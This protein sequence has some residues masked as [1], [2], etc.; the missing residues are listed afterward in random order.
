M[1]EFELPRRDALKAGAGLVS[2]AAAGLPVAALAA[3][4]WKPQVF[5]AHQ[6]ATVDQL[7][8]LIIPATDTPGA[9]AAGVVRYVDL[10]LNDGPD[11]E[12]ARFLEGLSWLDG[13]SLNKHQKPFV[14]LRE[15]EQTGVL[16]T[17]DQQLEVGVE[18][19]HRFFRMAKSLT[20]RI[21]YNTKIGYDELNK[22]GRVPSSY[23]CA[24]KPALP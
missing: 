7:S 24:A 20:S 16:K 10:F 18:E 23:G 2:L 3:E 6:M 5:D 11:A 17:L 4:D 15:A 14:Q 19:G 22:G 8:E 1:T 13:Y 12:R 21:Y 9:R